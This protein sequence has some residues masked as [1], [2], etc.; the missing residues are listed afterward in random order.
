MV[1]TEK[2]LD[3]PINW[4]FKVARIWAID[5][6]VHIVFILAAAIL[7]AMELPKEGSGDPRSFGQ[8][9]V[10]ALGIYAI[11]FAIVLLHEFGHCWG[12]RRV[13]GEAEEILLWPLGGLATVSPPNDARSHLVT[14]IAGPM[15]N[16]IICGVLSGVIA[17]WVGSLGAV[18]WNPIHP[19]LPAN[20]SLI[21]TLTTAQLWTIRVFGL[22]YFLLLI[23]MLPIFPFDGGRVLQSLL[24]PSKGYRESM[25]IATATGMV[26]A[27]LIGLLALFL[28]QSWI[29]LMIAGFGYITCMQQ[30][31]MA[32]EE[33]A[34][35]TG[36]FGYDFS[37]GYAAFDEPERREK[38]PG[39][40]ARWRNRRA[41]EKT[42][43]RRREKEAH[44]LAVE[45]ILRKIGASGIDSLTPAERRTL[46]AETERKRAPG[47]D[48]A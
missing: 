45:E 19:M 7:L 24:W 31:R 32:K 30:R 3:N 33:A 47:D 48:K 26:G 1:P 39:P 35:E 10:D 25:M 8:A 43:H 41:A 21:A 42:E 44:R 38:K 15:V 23:N 13:G 22:S 12:A 14:A 17:F 11:L 5:I 28:E 20:T 29:L 6:R 40:I 34:F 9:A 2:P 18:P 27:I 37:R 4:S 46:E 16:V 36:E